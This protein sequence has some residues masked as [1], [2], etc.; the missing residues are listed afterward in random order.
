MIILR[1]NKAAF[2]SV[3]FTLFVWI[4]VGEAN[5][6]EISWRMHVTYPLGMPISGESIERF[7]RLVAVNTKGT[8][9]IKAFEPGALVP[10]YEYIDSVSIG[11]IDAAWGALGQLVGREPALNFFSAIPFG[12]RFTEYIA[13][14]DHGGGQELA[15]EI[16]SDYNIHPMFCHASSPEAGGWYRKE[17]KSLDDFK[18][19]KMRFFGPGADVLKK[20]GAD[21]QLMP[22]SEIYLALELGLIETT[23]FGSPV[24]DEN[25]GFDQIAK[26]YYLPGWHAQTTLN[27]LLINRDAYESLSDHQRSVLETTCRANLV[28]TFVNYESVQGAALKSL[29]KK[30]VIVHKWPKDMLVEFKKAWLEV[31]EGEAATDE[32]YRKVWESLKAFRA[33][34]SHWR[35]SG[36]LDSYDLK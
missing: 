1:S 35:K 7:E 22:G 32:N 29:K 26:H 14:L 34:Y 27:A 16:F 33:E 17:V 15:E 10:A 30:G 20:F 28:T 31:A 36:Y 3:V 4:T 6:K 8:L 25:F 18:G 2:I 21:P 19:M 12:P 24:T 13:W 5:G 11:A 23:E 9:Q